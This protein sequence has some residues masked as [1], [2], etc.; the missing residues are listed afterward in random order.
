MNRWLR[1]GVFVAASL[2]A[3]SVLVLAQRDN[4][5]HSLACRDSWY[6]ERLVGHCEVRE[7][8]LPATGGTISVDGRQNGGV[9]VKGWER[10]EIQVRARI[11]SAALSQPE[12][13]ELSKQIKI[14]TA[15]GRIFANGPAT[16]RD[17]HWD[18]SYE[19]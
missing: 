12:A 4:S 10:N 6:S 9:S 16:Q 15:G 8:T 14:E 7:Q 19:I 18:V 17:F 1:C 3:T 5:N 11:Q 2:S 13:E